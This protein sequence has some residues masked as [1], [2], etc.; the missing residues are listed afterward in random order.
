VSLKVKQNNAVI[1]I[2]DNGIGMTDE[3]KKHIFDKFFQVD[4]SHSQK[5]IGLGL[6]I[7]LRIFAKFRRIF[8]L[9]LCYDT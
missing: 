8:S 9:F 6:S 4:N 5:G 2:K 3:V 1:E 7:V